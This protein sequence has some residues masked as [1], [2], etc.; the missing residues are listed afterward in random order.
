MV[1]KAMTSL[2]FATLTLLTV[3]SD[4]AVAHSRGPYLPQDGELSV[5]GVLLSR[6]NLNERCEERW[7]TTCDPYSEYVLVQVGSSYEFGNVAYDCEEIDDGAYGALSCK[8]TGYRKVQSYKS[9]L[10]LPNPPFMT[11]DLSF[12]GWYCD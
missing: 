2:L 11:T 6:G 8:Q 7:E 3:F 1:S 12:R 5:P 4:T 9:C 10:Q